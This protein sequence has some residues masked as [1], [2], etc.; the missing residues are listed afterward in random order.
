MRNLHREHVV[1]NAASAVFE[2]VCSS[3]FNSLSF[4][5][6]MIASLGG[7]IE[8]RHAAWKWGRRDCNGGKANLRCQMTKNDV[9]AWKKT[10]QIAWT[11]SCSP[12][13]I[14]HSF[15]SIELAPSQKP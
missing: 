4:S 5:A 13:L 11:W 3:C 12:L 2:P 6:C 1:E 15:L 14:L 10:R 9:V 8:H 7:A